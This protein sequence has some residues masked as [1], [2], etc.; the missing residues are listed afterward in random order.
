MEADEKKLW[1][2]YHKTKRRELLEK[3]VEKYLYLVHYLAGKLNIFS[4]SSMEKD[5]LYSAGVMGLLD[6]IEKFDPEKGVE[7]QTFATIRVRGSI[8]DEIR[9]TDWV[10]RSV[11]QKSKHIDAAIHSLFNRL[12]RMPSDSQVAEELDISLDEYY[13][14]TDN[15]GPMFLA[16]L[17]SAIKGDGGQDLFVSDIVEDTGEGVE[18]EMQRHNL[19]RG[20][21]KAIGQLPEREKLVISLYYYEELTL[22]EIGMVLDV[23]ESRVSQMHSSALMKLRNLLE[24]SRPEPIL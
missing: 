10:P 7:F 1:E 23:T 20:I 16:S 9:R 21:I 13:H 17:D 4:S 24:H 5:D 3:I 22:K 2:L 15:L 6:A 8:I 11:R 14:I 18:A 19:R 12:G